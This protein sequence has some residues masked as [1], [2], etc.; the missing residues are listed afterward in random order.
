MVQKNKNKILIVEDD[1][2]F[3]WIVIQGLLKENFSVVSASNGQEGLEMIKKEKPDLVL[4]DILMPIMDGL[5]MLE[6]LR[7]GGEYEKNLPVILLTNLSANSEDIIKKV[8]ETGPAHYIVKVNFP[9][10]QIVEKVKE[11]LMQK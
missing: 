3:V 7:H 9:V 10:K 1:E 8:A 5:T 11:L 2:D 4:L 6:E